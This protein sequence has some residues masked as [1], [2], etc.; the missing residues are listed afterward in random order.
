MWSETENVTQSPLWGSQAK[1]VTQSPLLVEK[2]VCDS[3]SVGGRDKRRDSI[4]SVGGPGERC[5][6]IAFAEEPDERC[7]SM[8]ELELKG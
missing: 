5:D 4:A 7:D 8:G 3:I 6:S 1:D 2:D